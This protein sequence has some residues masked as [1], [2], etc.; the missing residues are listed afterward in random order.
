MASLPKNNNRILTIQ[1]QMLW[2]HYH[3]KKMRFDFYHSLIFQILWLNI[4]NWFEALTWKKRSE[5]PLMWIYVY[6]EMFYECS[7]SVKTTGMQFFLSLSD[8]NFEGAISKK[9]RTC[10]SH[11]ICLYSS[12]DLWRFMWKG[13]K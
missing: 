2:K 1:F 13:K 12:F 8:G 9:R 3:R 10:F 4:P 11:P 6:I 7:W 5:I